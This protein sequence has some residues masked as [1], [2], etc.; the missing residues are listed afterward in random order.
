MSTPTIDQAFLMQFGS[1][2]H[3]A[4]QR[5]GS[6]VRGTVR[7]RSFGQA[8]K[9]RFQRYGKG[10]RPKQ[11]ARHAEIVPQNTKHDF[12]DLQMADYY[13]GEYVDSMDLLKTN[14][15]ERQLVANAQAYSHG[16]E[17]DV[18]LFAAM[19]ANPGANDFGGARKYASSV[20]QTLTKD[21]VLAISEDFNLRDIPDDGMRFTQTHP[22]VW[23]K[24]MGIAEFVNRDYLPESELPWKGGMVAKRWAGWAWLPHSGVPTDANGDAKTFFYH[25]TVVGHGVL[26]ELKTDVTWQGTRQAWFIATSMSQAAVVIDNAGCLEVAIDITP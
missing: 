22:K 17:T 7:A 5:Q 9:H 4:F 6:K 8:D 14:I 1:D 2:V 18:I 19:E 15:E 20:A 16:R 25:K 23:T 11:K 12:V 24:L 13:N 10:G 26:Q 21:L 3:V